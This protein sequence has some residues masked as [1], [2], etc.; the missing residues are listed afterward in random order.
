MVQIYATLRWYSSIN[1]RADARVSG[2]G[3]KRK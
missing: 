1:F 2:D 3:N